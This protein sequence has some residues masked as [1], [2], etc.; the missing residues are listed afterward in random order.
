[1][2]TASFKVRGRLDG[3]GGDKDG[4]FTIDR[5]SGIVTVRPKGSRTTYQT[6]IGR[7]ATWVCQN[8]MGISP[9]RKDE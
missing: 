7:L 8:T 9:S 6:T 3:A 2:S 4:T 5:E 1:M